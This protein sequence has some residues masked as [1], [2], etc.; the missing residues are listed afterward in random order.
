MI[1]R[2]RGFLD[3]EEGLSAADRLELMETIA[4]LSE[5]EEPEAT[6]RRIRAGEKFRDWRPVH[7]ILGAPSCRQLCRL[8]SSRRCIYTPDLTAG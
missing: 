7:G 8:S 2:L 3:F 5:P 4:E 1:G 6:S